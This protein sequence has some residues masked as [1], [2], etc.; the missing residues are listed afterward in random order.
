MFYYYL[1][2]EIVWKPV[3]K[4]MFENAIKLGFMIGDSKDGG[5]LEKESLSL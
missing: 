3:E 4:R 2:P 1:L 5:R